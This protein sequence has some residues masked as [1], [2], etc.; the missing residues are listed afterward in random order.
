MIDELHAQRPKNLFPVNRTN[1]QLTFGPYVCSV[2]CFPRVSAA[3]Q[4]VRSRR[5]WSWTTTF[6]GLL[7]PPEDA[8]PCYAVL[9]RVPTGWIRSET[10]RSRPRVA[11]PGDSRALT[12]PQLDRDVVGRG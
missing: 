5:R 10:D 8:C 11:D 6:E 1:Y 4:G 9:L 3:E 12:A 7:V 2:V